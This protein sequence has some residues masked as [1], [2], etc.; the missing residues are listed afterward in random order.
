MGF[1][2]PKAISE[3]GIL[4][5]HPPGMVKKPVRFNCKVC[6]CKKFDSEKKGWGF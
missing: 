5:T 1:S 3:M 6:D 2:E 4:F